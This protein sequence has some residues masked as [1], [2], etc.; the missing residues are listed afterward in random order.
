VR[1]KTEEVIETLSDPTAGEDARRR[2][3][4]DVFRACL[5]RWRQSRAEID[6]GSS[7]VS[8][9]SPT[10]CSRK[11]EEFA[12]DFEKVSRR[13]IG[14]IDEVNQRRFD[15]LL[16]D[17]RFELPEELETRLGLAIFL[18]RPYALYPPSSYFSVS[19]QTEM[20]AR[21]KRKR[22]AD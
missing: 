5:S 17:D 13:H 21:S 20:I 22:G 2:A 9:E 10:L 3:A 7:Q 15:R 6:G 8:V 19:I 18:L 16:R 14:A 12:A 11:T 1:S 4:R